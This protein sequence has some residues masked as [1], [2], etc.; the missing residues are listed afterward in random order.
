M[1][2]QTITNISQARQELDIDKLK[3]GAK[4]VHGDLKDVLNSINLI[5]LCIIRCEDPEYCSR[6]NTWMLQSMVDAVK[7]TLKNSINEL[8][9]N[10]GVH[11]FLE[12]DKP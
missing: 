12:A 7:D 2:E 8:F 11:K 3:K 6:Y 4:F 1:A 9:I 10:L 5:Q